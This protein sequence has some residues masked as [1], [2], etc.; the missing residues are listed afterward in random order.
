MTEFPP[1]AQD[2]GAKEEGGEGK[3]SHWKQASAPPGSPWGLGDARESWAQCQW[4][5]PEGLVKGEAFRPAE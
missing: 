2:P 3:G 4:G 1:A 5:P